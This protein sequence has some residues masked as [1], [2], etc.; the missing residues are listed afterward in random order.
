MSR[1]ESTAL[2]ATKTLDRGNGQKARLKERITAVTHRAD[3]KF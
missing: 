3:R 2:H 1:A